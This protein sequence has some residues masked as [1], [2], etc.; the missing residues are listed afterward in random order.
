MSTRGNTI[1]EAVVAV[2]IAAAVTFCPAGADPAPPPATAEVGGRG[3]DLVTPEEALTGAGVLRAEWDSDGPG[4]RRAFASVT[5]AAAGSTVLLRRGEQAA[6]L[7]TV[8][9]PRGYV[10]S[11]ASELREPNTSPTQR[12]LSGLNV[13]AKGD[14]FAGE[15]ADEGKFELLTAVLPGGRVVGATWVAEDRR[16][17]LVLLRLEVESAERSQLR[18]VQWATAIAAEVDV[19]GRPGVGR[20]VVV[21]GAVDEP[22]VA[23]RVGENDV[24]GERTFDERGLRELEGGVPL[25]V[26]I[27]SAGVRGVAGVRLGV[28]LVDVPRE[29]LPAAVAAALG[30]DGNEQGAEGAVLVTQ[31]MAG[32]GAAEAGVRPGDWVL[33]IAGQPIRSGQQLIDAIQETSEGERL[34]V[35]VLRAADESAPDDAGAGD[36]LLQRL[37]LEVEM[38]LRPD[39]PRSRA[40]R[41]NTMGNDRSRRR[42]G[43]AAVFQHDA[44]VPPSRCGGPVL[45]LDG[46]AVGL[47][48]ARA[49][50][51]EMY[52]LP[53]AT[54][55][56][57]IG[58]WVEAGV[59]Q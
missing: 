47:N 44:L 2:G 5:D 4:V 51:V 23:D 19:E 30:E 43:F 26:G 56:Q 25:A 53:A 18:A 15:Q 48:I 11:K 16:T 1:W 41:M 52:A 12:R 32:M 20:W 21:P 38:R 55:Q 7:G 28:G 22:G 8:I 9:D 49:G 17:D 58:Q 6:A 27:V 34:T 31:L 42:D 3:V 36:A 29:R 45:D 59:V 13:E 37:S 39:D 50:R 40:D 33:A 14:Q 10:V 24:G 54:V 57:V 35:E 46:R